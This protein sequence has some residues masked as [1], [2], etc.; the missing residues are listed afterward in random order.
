MSPER[1]PKHTE[2][3]ASTRLICAKLLLTIGVLGVL[4]G[5]V[6]FAYQG[7]TNPVHDSSNRS[8]IDT[9][10]IFSGLLTLLAGDRLEKKAGK[11]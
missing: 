5:A 8:K 3:R 10:L 4:G 1:R 7:W 6:D 2:K 11:K 9:G